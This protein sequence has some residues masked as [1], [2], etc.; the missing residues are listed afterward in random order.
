[1]RIAVFY[2]AGPFNPDRH[3]QVIAYIAEHHALPVSN[4]LSQSYHPPLYYVL[5]APFWDSQD[6]RPVHFISLLFSCINLWLIRLLLNRPMLMPHFGSRLFAMA[7]AGFLPQFVMFGSFI[8]NDPLTLLV[9]TLIFGAAA[10]YALQPTSGRLVLLGV[11]V[12]VGLLTK[13]TFILT[14]PALVLLVASI[15]ASRGPR[16]LVQRVVI[17]CLV[18]VALG[19]FKYVDNWIRVGWPIVHN[20]DMGGEIYESQRG[21]WKGPQTIYDIDVTKLI[22][23]PILQVRNTYSYPLLM[24]GT[25]WY[26]HI[27]DSSFVGSWHGYKWVGS[28]IYAVAVV[29]TLIFLGGLVRGIG[30]TIRALTGPSK[31]RDRILAIAVLLLLS[32]VTVV[33]AAGVKYDAWSNFQSRLCFQSMLPILVL[34]GAGMELLPRK[35]WMD[36]LVIA[37]CGVTIGA[38]LLYFGI[39]L[40]IVYGMLQLGEAVQP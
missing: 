40:G 39:E 27:P 8:S 3:D 22:R 32:N 2:A 33:I 36:L 38:C 12:A 4:E 14:G 7:I 13:G 16:M 5:A 23:R 20:L 29:P 25:F 30:R 37:F 1:M 11:M 28:L 15:E 34:F 19:C 9:G 21:T 35:K 24:Y 31:P 10:G 18:F 6:T 17:F 26:P